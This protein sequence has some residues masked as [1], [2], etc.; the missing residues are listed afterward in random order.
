[1]EQAKEIIVSGYRGWKRKRER[2]QGTGLYRSAEDSLEEREKRKLIERETWYLPRRK[3][4]EAEEKSEPEQ[5]R[6]VMGKRRLLKYMK[7]KRPE[8][9]G[10]EKEREKSCPIKAVMYHVLW[11]AN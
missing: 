7:G 1:M 5:R 8:Q 9:Q 11:V 4:D 10:G 6:M 3:V 2:R